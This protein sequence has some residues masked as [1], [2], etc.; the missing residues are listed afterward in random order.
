MVQLHLTAFL[1]TKEL[2]F[3]QQLNRDFW[4][5]WFYHLQGPTTPSASHA[6]QGTVNELGRAFICREK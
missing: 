1:K 6:A 4:Q 2:D 3:D 5:G